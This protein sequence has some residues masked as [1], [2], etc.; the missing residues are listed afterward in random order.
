MSMKI[1][2]AKSISWNNAGDD[3]SP[4]VGKR[5][6]IQLPDGRVCS[7]VVTKTSGFE[8]EFID[9]I[10]LLSYAFSGDQKWVYLDKD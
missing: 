9:G 4:E 10:D 8:M 2:N 5:V 6:V 3:G 1:K 7:G